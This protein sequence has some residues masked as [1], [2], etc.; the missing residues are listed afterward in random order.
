MP[1]LPQG[2]APVAPQ[3]QQA[4]AGGDGHGADQRD[5]FGRAERAQ[6]QVDPAAGKGADRI[7]PVVAKRAGDFVADDVAQHTTEHAGDDT[8]QHTDQRRHAGP[9]GHVHP[10]RGK[11]AQAQRIGDLHDPLGRLEMALAH[12]Q[13]RCRAQRQNAPDILHM[14]DPEEG[15]LVQQQVAQRA[16]T[17][18]SHKSHHKDAHGIKPAAGSHHDPGEGKGDGGRQFQRM[19]QPAA[20]GVDV[21][22]GTIVPRWLP[23]GRVTAVF[24]P[25]KTDFRW[26]SWTPAG[27]AAQGSRVK[28]NENN[29]GHAHRMDLGLDAGRST[30]SAPKL[31]TRRPP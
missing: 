6:S 12:E 25:W 15:P 8:H 13:H 1:H 28:R 14:P 27:A 2:Q 10:H 26:I 3:R 5:P 23:A 22:H 21:F 4:Q 17:K 9:A 20:P 18:S 11:Q 29:H 24:R 19:A 16:A 7:R 30:G 31:E